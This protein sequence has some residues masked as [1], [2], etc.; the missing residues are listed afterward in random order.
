MA[1]KNEVNDLSELFTKS[2]SDSGVWTQAVLLGK[3]YEIEVLVIGADSDEVQVYSREKMREMQKKIS[4]GRDK[5]IDIDDEAID[6]IFENKLDE[7]MV[8]FKG[9]RKTG[10]APLM[11]GDKEIP[12]LKTRECEDVYRKILE[13]MPALKDFIMSES[14]DRTN[15]LSSGKKN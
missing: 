15:F 3:K 6:S 5:H 14:N 8:R 13:G 2:N 12:V 1:K 9:I 7:A 11:L 10:G 4:V